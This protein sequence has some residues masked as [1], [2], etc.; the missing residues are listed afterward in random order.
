MQTVC[1]IWLSFSTKGREHSSRA[2]YRH[3]SA[4][5]YRQKIASNRQPDGRVSVILKP[6]EK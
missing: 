5:I 4:A 6:D 2:K 3:Y 1:R